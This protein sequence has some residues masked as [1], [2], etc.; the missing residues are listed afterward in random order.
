MEQVEVYKVRYVGDVMMVKE[1]GDFYRN[2]KVITIRCMKC[3][4]LKKVKYARYLSEMNGMLLTLKC[5]FFCQV[6]KF[7][8]TIDNGDVTVK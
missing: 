6:C 7:R 3:G 2:D 5:D 8:C 4:D 1:K